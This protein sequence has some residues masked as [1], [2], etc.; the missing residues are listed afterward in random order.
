VHKRDKEKC[1][2]CGRYVNGEGQ[3]HHLFRRNATI[4]PEYQIP[5]V[6]RNHHP[7]NLILLCPECH[8]RV[9]KDWVIDVD[10]FVNQNKKKKLPRNV[11]RWVS[12]NEVGRVGSRTDAG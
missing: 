4:P 8:N 3:I 7:Y 2:L 12:R 6:P 10:F 9:H 11:Q 5:W 1:R